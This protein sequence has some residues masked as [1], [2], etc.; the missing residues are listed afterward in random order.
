MLKSANRKVYQFN[1]RERRKRR[2]EID[3]DHLSQVIGAL[4]KLRTPGHLTSDRINKR[5]LN[6]RASKSLSRTGRPRIRRQINDL[7][8]TERTEGRCGEI[9]GDSSGRWRPTFT[10]T[11][12][13]GDIENPAL[14]AH[15]HQKE[16]STVLPN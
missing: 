15:P 14:M 3:A 2:W 12:L 4:S 1:T 5:L 13:G 16:A 7:G 10:L 6:G 8:W 11:R 9:G